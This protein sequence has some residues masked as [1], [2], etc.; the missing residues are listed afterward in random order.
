MNGTNKNKYLALSLVLV[1]LSAALLVACGAALGGARRAMGDV[2]D[3]RLV[4]I[5]D[6]LLVRAHMFGGDPIEGEA[7]DFADMNGDD[8]L[9]IDD[10]LLI[11]RVVFGLDTPTPLPSG[12]PTAVPSDVPTAGPDRLFRV[13]GPGAG[14]TMVHP[15]ISPL[16][17][18]LW[19]IGCDMSNNFISR[20]GGNRFVQFQSNFNTKGYSFDP[21][22]PQT[23]YL[24]GNGVWRSQDG[25]E[26]WGV[27]FP[28][29]KDITSWG[30]FAEEGMA[31]VV[32]AGAPTFNDYLGDTAVDPD[33]G[34]IYTVSTGY[35]VLYCSRD[36][37]ETFAQVTTLSGAESTRFA[38]I[39]IDPTSPEGDRRVIVFTANGVYQVTGGTAMHVYRESLVD[40][41]FVFDGQTTHYFVV[42]SVADDAKFLQ[43][44]RKSTDLDSWTQLPGFTQDLGSSSHRRMN[45]ICAA[46]PDILYVSVQNGR[47]PQDDGVYGTIKSTDGGQTWAWVFYSKW[48]STPANVTNPAWLENVFGTGWAGDAWGMTVSKSNPD[49]VIATNM[50]TAYG[51]RDGGVTWQV[52]PNAAY[53]AETKASSTSGL[54]VTAA[55]TL[56]ID[57]QDRNHMFIGY[58]DVGG[59]VSFDRG[60][61]WICTSRNGIPREWSNSC[62]G[63]VFDPEVS[64]LCWSAWA[65]AHEVPLTRM[66]ARDLSGYQ[67][68]VCV[69]TDGGVNW[70]LSNTGLPANAICTDLIMDPTS[71]K[72]ARVFYVTVLNQGVYR[73]VDN[74]KTWAAFNQGINEDVLRAIRI[75][76]NG[77]T[78]ML[79]ISTQGANARD[80]VPGAVYTLQ[81]GSETWEKMTLPDNVRAVTH[82]V[83]DPTRPRT[84]YCTGRAYIPTGGTN[85]G[86]A[87]KSTD[88]GE[89]WVQIFNPRINVAD[90]L[91][92]SR[93]PQRVYL[94][95]FDGRVMVSYDAGDTFKAIKGLGYMM[96]FRI[97]EDPDDIDRI[98]VCTYGGG[99]WH[100]R[101]E[102]E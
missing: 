73:S 18:N 71:P 19:M 46:T 86:G 94:A 100:G 78:L 49:L 5:D 7:F 92:D 91:V 77:D 53:D 24:S 95:T 74:G 75:N 6:I 41:D 80:L 16:D 88:G 79:N 101:V 27:I 37:G 69:S 96:N 51:T 97:F 59:F 68:G 43:V 93:D 25:G 57:P 17:D 83:A 1:L 85:F 13:I 76:W 9:D 32:R 31:P 26:T 12:N 66:F 65:G 54:D 36:N 34:Y 56:Q 52:L 35:S 38:K 102:T 64:G 11:R 62:Y 10:I 72:D 30:C 58:C 28:N 60:E 84:L 14:G 90:I 70:T 21:N 87:Y 15:A 29:E 63:F 99:V 67:G 89:T 82:I 22:D 47:E 42:Q 40:A 98:Y 44:V 48:G 4:D 39:Y 20:D 2:N 45:F 50:G 3:D 33:T 61:S 81:K 55:F 23:L 8:V